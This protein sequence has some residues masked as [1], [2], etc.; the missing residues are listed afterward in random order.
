MSNF[1]PLRP[2]DID[3]SLVKLIEFS[4]QC[5]VL[6]P[7]VDATGAAPEY[8]SLG[9]A[10]VHRTIRMEDLH[11]LTKAMRGHQQAGSWFILFSTPWLLRQADANS[12]QKAGFA[13]K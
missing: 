1:K 8:K 9:H 13:R 7:F 3:E 5:H 10:T 12:V 6:L 11:A 2:E 4:G